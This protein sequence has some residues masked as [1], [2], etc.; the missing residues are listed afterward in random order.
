M[1]RFASS[2]NVS[3][4]SSH[5]FVFGNLDASISISILTQISKHLKD[6]NVAPCL[7]VHTQWIN[8]T[9]KYHQIEKY[10]WFRNRKADPF[11]W[12]SYNISTS[13]WGA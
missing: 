12:F 7:F 11:T 4:R 13:V 6:K 10:E 1:S 9:E 5:V 3:I 8:W 2:D